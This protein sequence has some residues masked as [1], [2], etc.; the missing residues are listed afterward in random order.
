MTEPFVGEIRPWAF[1]WAPQDW[2]LCQGQQLPVQ[3][4]IALYSLL[5]NTYGGTQNVNFNLPDLRG[6]A[7]VGQGYLSFNGAVMNPVPY[8]MGMNAGAETV[9]IT[10]DTMPMHNHALMGVA[11][12]GTLAPA[13]G[14]LFAQPV[15]P[16]ANQVTKNLYG[17]AGAMTA[18]NAEVIGNAG[19]GAA[20]ENM[21]PFVVMNFCICYQGIFPP[22]P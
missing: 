11:T 14:N 18:L 9:A 19:S 4:Y 5:G 10:A 6:R 8:T 15:V 2:L 13:G 17:P 22:R 21:Q 3:Q 20:H 7:A 16:P 1:N 12:N